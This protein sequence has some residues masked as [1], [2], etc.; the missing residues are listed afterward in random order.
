MRKRIY[1]AAVAVALIIAA[2]SSTEDTTTT[3]EDA[4]PTGPSSVTFEDQDS[5]GTS[6]V[7]ASVT[8]PADG[9]VA[10]H[11]DNNGSPGAVIGHSDLLPAGESTDVKVT[12]DEAIT[13]STTLWPMAHIDIDRDGVYTFMPPDN[14]IDVPGTTADGSV[15]V[16]GGAVNVLPPSAPA[17]LE[18]EAQDSD[19]TSIVV[20]SVTLPAQGFI[21][22][23]ADADGAPGAVI[24]HSDLLPAGN[25]TDVKVTLDEAIT[26]STTL[27]PMVHIDL[28]RDG[29]YLFAPPDNAVDL[30]GVTGGGDVAVISVAINVLPPTA[31]SALAADAQDSD[32]TSIVVA[33]VTLPA[34]GF[35][36]VHADADGAPGA[37]IGHS[38]L[39]QA[40]DSTD[41][42]VTFDEAITESTTL[43]PMVHIDID[44]DGVY[45]FMPPD[46]AIDVP[47]ITADGMVAVLAVEVSIG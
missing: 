19:G 12:L 45:T 31:P 25:S 15:A 3:L 22:V 24:G 5:D 47:G 33:S 17:S 11:A 43:W 40:G 44:G 16:V 30:P 39:L 34:N 41:V 26:E 8:L 38:D 27:W 23:H 4:P 35:I 29:S 32:G 13:E 2:C 1:V 36:A 7:V 42:V 21:A 46:N 6:V 37:V 9:F 14:A 18:A 10:V 20:A 28:D